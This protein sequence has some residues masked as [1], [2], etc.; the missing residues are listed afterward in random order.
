L[1]GVTIMRITKDEAL[2]LAAALDDYKFDFLE[3]LP[4][5]PQRLKAMQVLESLQTRLVRNG[6][7]KRRQGRSSMNSFTDVLRRYCDV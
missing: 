3:L 6:K 4:D 1:R 5:K 7:D 2:I